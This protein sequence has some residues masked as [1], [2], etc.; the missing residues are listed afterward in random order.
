VVLELE[1]ARRG[2]ARSHRGH[3][4]SSPPDGGVGRHPHGVLPRWLLHVGHGG[5]HQFR[6]ASSDHVAD[7]GEALPVRGRAHD[8][9]APAVVLLGARG[10][11]NGRCG[12]AADSSGAVSPTQDVPSRN[13]R[14]C[15][16]S[17]RGEYGRSPKDRGRRAAG[18]MPHLPEPAG[19]AK[20]EQQDLPV[21]EPLSDRLRDRPAPSCPVLGLAERTNRWRRRHGASSTPTV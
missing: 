19:E 7:I 11:S 16:P 15:H 17:L 13:A 14:S 4:E 18:C 5:I 9:A 10:C 6:C 12:G 21:R 2:R 3:P 20:D 8:R 1:R